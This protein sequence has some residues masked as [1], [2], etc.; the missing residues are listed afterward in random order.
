MYPQ[1]SVIVPVYKAE[2][3]LHRC[4]D[5]ILAQTF[6][7]FELILV[8]DGSPDGSGAICDE[9][10]KKDKRVKVIHKE[11]GGV[12]A[13][14]RDGVE[15]SKGEWITFVDSDDTI[16]IDALSIYNKNIC[17]SFDIIRGY[18]NI[19]GYKQ[20]YVYK[21]EILSYIDYRRE[22][23]QSIKLSSGPWASLIRNTMFNNKT[24]NTPRD[25][26]WGEDRIMNI[27]LAFENKKDV[28]VLSEPT[29][30]YIMNNDSCVHTFNMTFGYLEDLYTYIL[31]S[32][33][34]EQF[35]TYIHEC[36]NFRLYFLIYLR[37]YYIVNNKWRKNKYHKDLLY[38]IKKSKYKLPKLDRFTISFSNPIANGI[39]LIISKFVNIA[40]KYKKDMQ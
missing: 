39:Y 19:I 6:T 11:N 23:I 17:D 3:Y 8:N 21:S 2:K 22:T 9:Y 32:I 18:F 35:E 28:K 5:S 16:P 10:A 15:V 38:D 34:K 31:N 33:P 1:I 14:R 7:D 25:I 30:N 26:V 20:E 12:T 27:R 13:A 36:I 37:K 24:F 40:N 29:Y 4:I